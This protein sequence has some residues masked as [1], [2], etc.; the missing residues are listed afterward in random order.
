MTIET[1]IEH[2]EE[3]IEGLNRGT[4]KAETVFRDLP[5]WDSLAVLTTIAM[6]DA[7]FEVTLSANDL[8]ECR[9]ISDLFA[10]VAA[11][12]S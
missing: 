11:R 6:V 10:L 2:F 1:F 7:E 5:Q 12:R 3:A 8:T 9:T 4:V